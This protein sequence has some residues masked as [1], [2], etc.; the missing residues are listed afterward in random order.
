MSRQQVGYLLLFLLFGPF[1]ALFVYEEGIVT[2]LKVLGGMTLCVALFVGFFSV[3]A[4]FSDWQRGRDRIANAKYICPNCWSLQGYISEGEICGFCDSE[5]TTHSPYQLLDAF[6]AERS[7]DEIERKL[8]DAKKGLVKAKRGER[9][10]W[11]DWKHNIE[12]VLRARR[13]WEGKG[14]M[15]GMQ[16]LQNPPTP[17]T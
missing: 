16:G 2:M 12:L 6:F 13:K 10:S 11:R 9:S 7:L 5:L 4:V 8:E 3:R 15:G 1:L 17:R 14:S